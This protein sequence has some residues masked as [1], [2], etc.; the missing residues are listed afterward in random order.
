MA[1]SSQDRKAQAHERLAR[2]KAALSLTADQQK[3][4]P[5][6]EA[7]LLDAGRARLQRAKSVQQ[8]R[9]KAGGNFRDRVRQRAE[10][11]RARAALV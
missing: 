2:F 6:V 7:A 8:L 10:G 5:S 4:W 11:L 1:L 3:Q 9:A